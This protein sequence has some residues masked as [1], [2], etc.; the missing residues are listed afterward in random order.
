MRAV[1]MLHSV[2][3]SGSEISL[4][5][6]ELLALVR[7][8]RT[9]GHAIVPLGELLAQAT[10]DAVALTF[11]DGL[12]SLA[13]VAQPLL[14]EEGAAATLFLT[15]GYV[16]RDNHWPSQPRSAPRL[17]MLDWDG[18]EA[19]HSAGWEIEAHTHSHPDLRELG[20]NELAEELEAP[21][22]ELERRLGRTPR[23]F[24]YPYGLLDARV[25]DAVATR[26]ECA[27]TTRMAALADDPSGNSDPLRI[28]RLDA[29]YLRHH[30]LQRLIRTS[31]GLSGFGGPA[32]RALIAFRAALRRWSGH[33]G[34][35]A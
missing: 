25:V 15:T 24:A 33:P 17:P 8:I 9:S 6:A 21:Q 14:S 18:V 16:G 19:L 11:D 20:S 35:C 3:S 32:F 22:R 1:L 30:T 13:E 12:A 4:A 5:P 27:V 26:Y 10:R 23:A 31:S 29:Y 2:D 28:P 7:G 34:E